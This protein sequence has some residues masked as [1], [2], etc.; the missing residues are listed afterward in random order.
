MA[1][2]FRVL[3]TRAVGRGGELAARLQ[4]AGCTALQ[5]PCLVIEPLEFPH[6]PTE[7]ADLDTFAAVIVVSP[8][9]AA[10]FRELVETYWPQWPQGPAWLATGRATAA[11]LR[12]VEPALEV[13]VPG[14]AEEDA[15]GVLR[16]PQ[17]QEV[18]DQRVLLV[19]GIGGRPE[20]GEELQQRGAC[21]RELAL[22]RRACPQEQAPVL[23]DLL[24]ESPPEVAV[25]LSGDTLDNLVR[26]AGG[27]A[28]RLRKVPICVPGERLERQA[29]E[30]GFDTVIPA[31]GA[32]TGHVL[33]AI[34][35]WRRQAGG[36]AG[37]GG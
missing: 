13:H 24:R 12:A 25:A 23:Q 19:K 15:S 18:S 37:A 26:L 33:R 9:A 20:L 28:S 4:Q 30:L 32:S 2:E 14:P 31:D 36:T 29:R 5:V 34:D 11:P 1:G 35:Q 10:L 17:L 21:L 27:L 6:Q 7:I 22:Y 8:A 16:L 3:L